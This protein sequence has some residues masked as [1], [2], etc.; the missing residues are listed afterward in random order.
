M[1]YGVYLNGKRSTLLRANY[2]SK[3]TA[4]KAAR[5]YDNVVPALQYEVRALDATE[6]NKRR[7]ER[8]RARRAS[9]EAKAKE[10]RASRLSYYKAKCRQVERMALHDKG[11]CSVCD[12]EFWRRIDP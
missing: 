5:V 8:Q 7:N 12:R 2:S 11:T 4:E 10:A 3:E 6:A 1:K 9:P